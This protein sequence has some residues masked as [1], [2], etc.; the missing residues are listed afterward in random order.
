VR[1]VLLVGLILFAAVVCQVT[2]LDNMPFPG[3]SPP[4]LVLLAVVALALAT[5]PEPGAIAG[6]TAGL[7]LDIA[8]PAAHLLGLSA[9][10]FC[11]VGYGCGKLRA[12]LEDASWLPLAGVA[13]GVAGGEALY[14]LAG[15][16]FGDPDITWRAARQV[17]PVAIAYELLLSPFVLYAVL[18]LLR[19]AES[20]A[21]A[22]PTTLL[23]GRELAPAG[24]GA[25]GA[26]GSVRDTGTGKRPKLS[27]KAARRGSGWIGV[28]QHAG[29][30]A[31]T[32][33]PAA[34]MPG[35]AFS[36]GKTTLGP[37]STGQQRKRAPRGGT[38][39]GGKNTLSTGRAPQRKRAPRGGTFSGGGQSGLTAPAR[40]P[41][42]VRLKLG[43]RGRRGAVVGGGMLS[44]GKSVASRRKVPGR[45]TFSGASRATPKITPRAAPRFRRTGHGG[46][47]RRWLGLG[48]RSGHWRSNQRIRGLR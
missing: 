41:R 42:Q 20:V 35:T 23:T 8:P 34:R 19:F 6:F 27:A 25:A 17:M 48:R 36:G 26:A 21:R 38:F 39:S 37:P 40:S 7:A 9:L 30:Q 45:G 5:G 46:L 1:R 44:R 12:P 4:S 18:W 43:S 15:L 16:T 2:V 13:L 31:A 3:G 10:V 32:T 11:L 29:G 28:R 22:S 33:R 14:A 47:L 24:A